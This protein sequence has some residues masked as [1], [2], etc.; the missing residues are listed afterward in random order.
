MHVDRESLLNMD[1]GGMTPE[2][3]RVAV[4]RSREVTAW[5]HD[6]KISGPE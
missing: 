3:I 1:I 2:H 6:T 5:S 4:G